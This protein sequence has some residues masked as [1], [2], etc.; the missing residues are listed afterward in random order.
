MGFGFDFYD[1]VFGMSV[2]S[3]L[4]LVKWLRRGGGILKLNTDGC[5]KP[6]MKFFMKQV[7]ANEL[8]T[9]I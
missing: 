9:V 6:N 2:N 3:S 1:E 5:S 7:L 8:E 4:K